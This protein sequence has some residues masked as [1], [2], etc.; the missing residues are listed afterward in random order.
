MICAKMNRFS[1]E[2][3]GD[4][5]PSLGMRRAWRLLWLVA[6]VLP[7][8]RGC[9]A[10]EAA[11]PQGSPSEPARK[12][13]WLVPSSERGLAM[14]AWLYRPP[15]A[16][17]FPLAVITHGSEQSA[18]LRAKMTL[19]PYEPAALWFVR[20]GYAVA[21]VQRPGHGETKGPYLE[22]QKGCADADFRGA[23]LGTAR[24]I[25]AAVDYFSKQRFVRAAQIVVVGHSA[26]GWGALALAGQNPK[27]VKAIIAF[28]PGRGGR[29]NGRANNNCAPERLV[30]AAAEFG[31]GARTPL[32]AIYAENDGSFPP[33]LANRLTAAYRAAGGLI[34]ARMLAAFG[35]DGHTLFTSPDGAALWGPVV[36]DFLAKK[37]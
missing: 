16:G 36:E 30:A 25:T 4:S 1:R 24:S 34:D 26:G 17:P 33:V 28:A 2:K 27:A 32:L 5:W 9:I 20:H 13:V 6:F 19:A 37:H 10:A 23:G 21:L 11:G 7:V 12:Q 18:A 31:A 14:Q 15:G 8:W 22:D 3:I 35:R 29:V